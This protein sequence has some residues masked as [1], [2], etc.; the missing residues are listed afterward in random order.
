[1]PKDQADRSLAARL[2]V[3]RILNANKGHLKA[4]IVIEWTMA[5][6]GVSVMIADLGEGAAPRT[7]VS[8]SPSSNPFG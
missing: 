6:M 3:Q 4:P 8:E 1:V 5:M 7:I 2:D